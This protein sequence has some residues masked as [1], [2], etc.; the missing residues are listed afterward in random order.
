MY[1]S[2]KP[3][4]EAEA[5]TQT[6]K[7]STGQTQ[8]TVGTEETSTSKGCTFPVSLTS[9]ATCVLEA[10]KQSTYLEEVQGMEE[11]GSL[12]K[13][14]LAKIKADP[15]AWMK[16]HIV[17]QAN[18]PNWFRGLQSPT[19]QTQFFQPAG[20]TIEEEKF[21]RASGIDPTKVP[22]YYRSPHGL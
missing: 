2:R 6:E 1:F 21:L 16:S 13:G 5:T 15:V 9:S 20:L 8:D 19:S 10:M 22:S 14:T 7:G 17:L 18:Y 3:E 4:S 12:P 11:I